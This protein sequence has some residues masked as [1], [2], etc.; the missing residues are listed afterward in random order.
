MKHATAPALDTIADLLE[1]VR[2]HEALTERKRGIFYLKST[3]FLHFHEDPAGLFA[4]LKIGRSFERFPVNSP[5]ECADLLERLE[6]AFPTG[7]KPR[8]RAGRVDQLLTSDSTAASRA[9]ITQSLE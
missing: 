1:A 4:D 6:E 8:S 2:E 5:D 9:R 3:A 7:R